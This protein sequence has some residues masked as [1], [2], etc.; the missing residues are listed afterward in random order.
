MTREEIIK[1]GEEQ[2]QYTYNQVLKGNSKTIKKDW[3]DGG[4][5]QLTMLSYILDEEYERYDEWF[6]KFYPYI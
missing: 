6:N 3:A 1:K 2:L 4:I 5:N